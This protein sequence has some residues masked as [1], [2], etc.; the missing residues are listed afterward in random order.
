MLCHFLNVFPGKWAILDEIHTPLC[1]LFNR[2]LH[3]GSKDSKCSNLFDDSV[4]NL[5]SL[6]EERKY[7]KVFHCKRDN[8]MSLPNGSSIPSL[9]SSKTDFFLHQ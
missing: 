6:M 9:F 3:R 2:I 7:E 1:K 4:P 5:N 8:V